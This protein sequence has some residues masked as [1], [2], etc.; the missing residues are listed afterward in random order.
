MAVYGDL[1]NYI[2]YNK[3]GMDLTILKE[4]TIVDA[5][6][7]S[8]NLATQDGT[9]M[10]AVVRLLGKLPKGNAGKFVILGTG[11]VS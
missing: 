9:A 10:R 11:T 3:K 4:A 7:Q 2:L 5:N 6:S 8:F 1:S